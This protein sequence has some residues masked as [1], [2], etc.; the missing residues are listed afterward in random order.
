MERLN[1]VMG[2][3]VSATVAGGLGGRL[4]GGWIHPP[5]H[6]RYA[7]I[8]V[9]ALVLVSILAAVCYLPKERQSP[10]SN[11]QDVG[12]LTLLGRGELLRIFSVA[13]FSFW[14][15]SA[16]FNY[17]PFYLAGPAF[18]ASTERI[19][20]MYTA[21]VLGI[22]VGLL[23]GKLSNR[24]GNGAT[25]IFGASVL[26]VSLAATHINSLWVVMFSLCGVCTGFFAVH[27]AAAGSLNRKL[28]SSRGRANSLYVLFYYLGGSIGIT[29]SGFG[30]QEFGWKGITGIS[31]VLLI[32]IVAAG[33]MELREPSVRHQGGRHQG[34]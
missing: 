3:Y 17:L 7:F 25:M 28:T 20:L 19:T 12:F 4:L 15:F 27:A 16:L 33:V 8:T 9:S 6:W 14:V 23:S 32:A 18:N 22:I 11:T 29:I 31:M 30:Y 26:A 24:I 34:G 5:L 2:S 21:Y 1:V 10:V 13:F